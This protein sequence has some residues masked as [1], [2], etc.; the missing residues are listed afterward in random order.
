MLTDLKMEVAHE[1]NKDFMGINQNFNYQ[2][3]N[4]NQQNTMQSN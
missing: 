3:V 1:L 2:D 4:T